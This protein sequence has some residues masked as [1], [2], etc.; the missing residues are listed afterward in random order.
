MKI[1]QLYPRINLTSWIFWLLFS[2]ILL[3]GAVYGLYETYQMYIPYPDCINMA[4]IYQEIKQHGFFTIKHWGFPPDNF[5]LN[6][7]SFY[8]LW[9]F[10]FGVSITSIVVF[11]YGIFFLNVFLTACLV[12]Y[13]TSNSKLAATLVLLLYASPLT[14]VSANFS[15][16]FGHNSAMV[17]VLLALLIIVD[18]INRTQAKVFRLFLLSSVI[19][20][21]TFSDPWFDAAFIV[22]SILSLLLILLWPRMEEVPP[23]KILIG[24][25]TTIVFSFLTG[26]GLYQI[27]VH[28]NILPE[29]ISSMSL[30]SFPE[31]LGNLKIFLQSILT[32]FNYDVN[33]A[34]KFQQLIYA[35]LGV[36]VV[37]IVVRHWAKFVR[38]NNLPSKF[39]IVF[40]FI[41]SSVMVVAYVVTKFVVDLSSTRYLLNIYYM[42]FLTGFIIL[43]STWSKLGWRKSI[44]IAWMILFS[45]PSVQSGWEQWK[46]KGFI[47]PNLSKS[48][49]IINFLV[50]NNLKDGLAPYF[51]GQIG[52]N[53]ITL[54]SE[55]Q[56]KLRPVGIYENALYPNYNNSSKLWYRDKEADFLIVHKNDVPVYYT[57]AV[58]TFGIPQKILYVDE[59]TL[60]I[61]NKNLMLLLK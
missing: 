44:I 43:G 26:H 12:K 49:E 54:L 50:Q 17:F 23:Q 24:I 19:I 3:I 31:M 16:P 34:L 33:A 51:S 39:V 55:N 2:V 57:A 22:P 5:L 9:F 58:N 1:L 15:H 7:F 30:A 46:Q 60:W 8:Y 59:Y 28:Y 32:L 45:V 47:Q 20:I 11:S 41:S 29:R 42:G 61:W 13:V 56:I 53:S 10:L 48:R 4:I 14:I 38:S 25:L 35:T 21:C 27:L 40:S 18:V 52:A 6:L 36:M 37:F